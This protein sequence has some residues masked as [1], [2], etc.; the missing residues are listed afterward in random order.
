MVCLAKGWNLPK[1]HFL[2]QLLPRAGWNRPA[3]QS[4]QSVAV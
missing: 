4:V 3:R 1:W 2:H